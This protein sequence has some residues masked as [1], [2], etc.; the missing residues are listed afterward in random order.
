ME[1]ALI[2]YNIKKSLSPK[3]HKLI[4]L[5]ESTN[6]NYTLNEINNL[7]ELNELLI[8]K[9]FKG[10]NITSPYKKDVLK[11]LDNQNEIVKGT[12]S[13]NTIKK[14]NNKLFG[15]NTDYLGFKDSL[16]Y[17]NLDLNNKDVYI[18][19]NGGVSLTVKKALEELGANVICICR[20]PLKN[21]NFKKIINIKDYLD[22]K[23][24]YLLINCSTAGMNNE[25]LF[26][27]E[28]YKRFEYGYDLIYNNTPFLNLVN[29]P[30]NGK[31]MVISQAVNA[32]EIW[33][34]KKIN[35][36][37]ELINKIMEN[38]L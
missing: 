27:N 19:G 9:Y 28:F 24:G 8:N 4:S 38:L 20:N 37:N 15:Y 17:Y 18:I 11:Y 6:Y 26:I 36:K 23:K 2:G 14:I 3:I 30:I 33:M 1:Y 12:N 7:K 22:I 34:D 32:Y 5:Y 25:Q 13:C 31:Y 21:N 35:H 29:N 10:I 16:L